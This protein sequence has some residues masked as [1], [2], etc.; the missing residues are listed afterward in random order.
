MSVWK[1]LGARFVLRASFNGDKFVSCGATAERIERDCVLRASG[2][3]R[4]VFNTGGVL[5]WTVD[6]VTAAGDHSN[7]LVAWLPQLATATIGPPL[8][9]D[10][11]FSGWCS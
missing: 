3:A 8:V 1:L 4:K 10:S 7:I 9:A 2:V 11:P 6:G 5:H